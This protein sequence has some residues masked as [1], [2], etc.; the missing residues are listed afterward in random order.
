[1]FAV[2]GNVRESYDWEN[3]I[4]WP[5]FDVP[6]DWSRGSSSK[7][8]SVCLSVCEYFFFTRKWWIWIP[9]AGVKYRRCPWSIW[10]WRHVFGSGQWHGHTGVGTGLD[11]GA[12]LVAA[13]CALKMTRDP[14]NT[15]ARKSIRAV[16]RAVGGGLNVDIANALRGTAAGALNRTA[17]ENL[18]CTGA[19]ALNG[20]A[21][22][23]TNGTATGAL[24]G[25]VIDGLP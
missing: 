19:G 9:W 25:I 15:G 13:I 6:W 11:K 16:A 23:T 21:A 20:T 4:W 24:N 5:G 10:Y 2:P 3:L 18:C 17:A 8:H 14:T 22:G 12:F 1:M 7:N